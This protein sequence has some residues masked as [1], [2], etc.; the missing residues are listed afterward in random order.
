MGEQVTMALTRCYVGA[1]RNVCVRIRYVWKTNRSKLER[2]LACTTWGPA[3]ST[4]LGDCHIVD[5]HALQQWNASAVVLSEHQLM[6]RSVW[7]SSWFCPWLTRPTSASRSS[8]K[9][10]SH[11]SYQGAIIVSQRARLSGVCLHGV[12][13]CSFL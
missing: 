1:L 7:T 8:K 6:K 5:V 13:L 10:P 11:C 3:L 12:P 4:S 2:L 9:K